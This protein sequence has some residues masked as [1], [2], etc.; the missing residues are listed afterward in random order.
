MR[1][2]S[3]GKVICSCRYRVILGPKH[4]RKVLMSLIDG[5]P[6]GPIREVCVDARS[7]LVEMGLKPDR[8][9]QVLDCDP[10]FGI[11][12]LVRRMGAEQR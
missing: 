11:N 10:Q 12:R 5:R 4:R 8:V 3:K 6:R 9:H 7:E 1:F 2:E